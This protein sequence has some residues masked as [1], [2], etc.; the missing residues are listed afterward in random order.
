[1]FTLIYNKKVIRV[2]CFRH[3][4]VLAGHANKE[5]A[6]KVPILLDAYRFLVLYL[7]VTRDE[8]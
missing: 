4:V 5:S 2:K 3:L 7:V 6:T 8:W 1:M